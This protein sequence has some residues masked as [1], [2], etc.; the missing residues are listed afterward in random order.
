MF[1]RARQTVEA[2]HRRFV[3]SKRPQTIVR[4]SPYAIPS[5]R[6]YQEELD[7]LY[8]GQVIYD[9]FI[10][11]IRGEKARKNEKNRSSS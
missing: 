7:R 2:A 10:R 9:E 3:A 8:K 11:K 5:S 1:Q 4:S 6:E